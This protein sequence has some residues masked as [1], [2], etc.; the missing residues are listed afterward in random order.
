MI[1]QSGESNVISHVQQ[2]QEKYCSTNL[3][4]LIAK[5]ITNWCF[6]IMICNDNND[7]VKTTACKLVELNCHSGTTDSVH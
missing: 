6:I 1:V 2:K 4:A 7:D 3:V 5:E